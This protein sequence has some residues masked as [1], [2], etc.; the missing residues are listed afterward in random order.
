M[1]RLEEIGFY[2]LSDKRAKETSFRSP[3][4]RLEMLLTPECNLHCPYCRG[5]R[6]SAF[7]FEEAYS[8]LKWGLVNGLV[9]VRFSGGEPTLYDGLGELVYFCSSHNVKRIAISTNGTAS[10]DSYKALIHLG[11]NDISISLD[12]CCAASGSEMNGGDIEAWE[13]SVSNICELSRLT[14]VTVGIVITDAN[15]LRMKETIEFAHKLGVADIRVIPSA[16][17][18][19]DFKSI[20]LLAEIEDAHPILRYRLERARNQKPI[21][22]LTQDDCHRCWLI[23]DDLAVMPKGHYPCIIYLREGGE[24][25]GSMGNLQTIRRERLTWANSHNTYLDPICQKNCLDV[26]IAYN[27]RVEQFQH[28]GE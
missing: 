22:G 9:N 14:Y 7:D 13:Q 8:I 2:T 10:R 28:N 4:Q 17:S 16:Q 20:Q 11:V 6:S 25:I 15:I 12:A 26:C 24:P 27:N 23:L 21:R 18:G 3:L 19:S 1:M 5:L